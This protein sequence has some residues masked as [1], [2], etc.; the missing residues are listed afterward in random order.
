MQM[1]M[2]IPDQ[3]TSVSIGGVAEFLQLAD[4]LD[5]KIQ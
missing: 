2:K 5:S 3:D 1:E 4:L